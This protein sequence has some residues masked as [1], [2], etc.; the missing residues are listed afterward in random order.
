[1]MSRLMVALGLGCV[2][3]GLAVEIPSV[4]IGIDINGEDVEMP[5]VGAGTWQYNDTTAYESVCKAF[6]AGYSFVDTAY[7]YRNQ[8]GVGQAIADCWKGRREDLFVM[9]KIPGGLQRG[10]A[11]AAHKRN[12]FELGLDYV[13]HLMTHFPADWSVTP[14]RSSPAMR[15]EE[16]LALEEVYRAGE[17]R[18]IG[19]SHYCPH[20]ID[21][22]LAVATISPSVNQVEYHVG[23]GDVDGVM[24]KCK[25]HNIT[26][27]SFSPLCGPCKHNSEDSLINGK[28]VSGIAQKHGVSGSQVSL[29]F[30]VQQAL[31][32]GSFVGAV[33]P[34]SNNA[35]HIASN[36]D[37]FS[38]RLSDDEMK[39]LAAASLPAAEAGDC[40]VP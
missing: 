23:S 7:G 34:K 18:S 21:D 27:M 35:V 17:A 25:Q 12:L 10:E 19:I 9:T 15:Q 1:M 38:F 28:L 8:R 13:D 16:W 32:E 31:T 4:T 29:R 14:N 37:V 22:I 26:F 39:T 33:I 36:L 20:H 30:I 24:E 40:D 5:L 6:N 3:G 2:G 11:L